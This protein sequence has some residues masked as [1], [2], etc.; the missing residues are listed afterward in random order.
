MVFLLAPI[1]GQRTR[2]A[3]GPLHGDHLRVSAIF[4]ALIAP[5]TCH[6]VVPQMKAARAAEPLSRWSWPLVLAYVVVPVV[7]GSLAG[8]VI[9]S[10]YPWAT[11][12]FGA[13]RPPLAWDHLF[14]RGLDGWVRARLR[15]GTWIGGAYAFANGR[16]S[17]ASGYPDA[18]KHYLAATV[19]VDPETGD[20]L[21]DDDGQL[22]LSDGG[23]LLK[24]DDVEYLEFVDSSEKGSS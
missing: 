18:Q 5:I 16:R 10:G 23:L 11:K 1:L 14:S 2:T 6:F 21:Y 17:Y 8:A 19:Q 20:W 24:W 15:S 13:N 3:P 4:H 22:V 9:R 7:A 12:L